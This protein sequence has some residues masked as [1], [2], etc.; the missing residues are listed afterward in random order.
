MKFE[1]PFLLGSLY[2]PCTNVSGEGT[3]GGRGRG[4][5]EVLWSLSYFCLIQ[6][7][8]LS[9]KSFKSYP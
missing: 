9:I 7:L 5:G 2:I 6:L 3:F 8:S 4:D 1:G